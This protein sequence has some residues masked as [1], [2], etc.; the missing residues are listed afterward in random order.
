M[1]KLLSL[2]LSLLGLFDSGYL[3]WVYTSPSRPMLCVGTGCDAVRASAYAHLWGVTIPA[4]G[5]AGYAA[6]ALIFFAECLVSERLARA[7][8]YL[9]LAM[10]GGGFLFSVYLSYLEARVIH[11][12]CEWCVVS[13]LTMTALLA[14]SI[15]DVWS[16][17]TPV[18]PAA[19]L[20]SARSRFAVFVA[21]LIIGVPAFLWLARRGALPPVPTASAE[22]LLERLVRPDSH[23]WGDP[24]APVT[25]VEFG[26]FQC[27]VCGPAEEVARKIRAKFGNRIK[28]VFR[29]FPLNAIHPWAEKSAEA[30]ECAAA[31]GKFW[32]MVDKLYANQSDLRVDALKRYAAELGLDTRRFNQCLT[33]GAMAPRVGR[34][35]RDARALGLRATPTFFIDRKMVEGA[36]PLNEFA[37]LIDEELATQGVLTAQAA[38]PE[39]DAPPAPERAR[40][41]ANPRPAKP[42]PSA[43]P[44]SG[45]GSSGNPFG[46]TGGGLFSVVQSSGGGCSEEEAAQRQPTMV[47]TSDVEKLLAENPKPVLVDVRRPQEYA[48]GHLPGAVNIPLSQ[49]QQRSET[50]PKDR[51]II[52]YESGRATGDICAASRS[53]GRTLLNQGFEFA[54]VKVYE[55]GLLGWEK[56]GQPVQQ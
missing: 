38:A 32:P 11:A 47:H 27:P 2:A 16:A 44:N 20:R 19:Q 26:D 33:S 51:T 22:T 55:D 37:Q 31:Q 3:L 17:A 21:A 10:T 13:A 14:L 34:D 23:V 30:S 4:Y 54:Y 52:V 8:R 36:L 9:A 12:W 50:L 42:A 41:A 1:R 6:L 35:E 28:F 24:Q 29:Q 39:A 43:T 45:M 5:V 49:I 46:Q 48:A 15:P 53:A 40:P 7:A 56:A 25:V 18:E